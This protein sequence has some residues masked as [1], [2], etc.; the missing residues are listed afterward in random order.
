MIGPAHEP[1]TGAMGAPI[2][3]TIQSSRTGAVTARARAGRP[4]CQ[5]AWLEQVGIPAR[6][7]LLIACDKGIGRAALSAAA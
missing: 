7:A 4:S 2:F 3:R 1:R 6:A 5:M